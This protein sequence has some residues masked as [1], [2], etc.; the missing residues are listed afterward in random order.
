[1]LFGAGKEVGAE[2]LSIK[3]LAK[4]AQNKTNFVLG[5]GCFRVVVNPFDP[6]G[7]KTGGK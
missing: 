2:N 5:Q 4:L 7:A 6:A 1:M 3:R